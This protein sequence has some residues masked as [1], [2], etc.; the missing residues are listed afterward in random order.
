M[1]IPHVKSR[2]VPA[3]GRNVRYCIMVKGE[4]LLSFG[5]DY[6]SCDIGDY[7]H[8]AH[9]RKDNCA[10]SYDVNIDIEICCKTCANACQHGTVPYP[11]KLL[12][13]SDTPFGVI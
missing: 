4:C 13:H 2:D 8:T 10:E 5:K 6:S 1:L 11:V 3:C 12:F 7:T 9:A